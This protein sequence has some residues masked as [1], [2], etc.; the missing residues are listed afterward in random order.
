MARRD[1]RKLCVSPFASSTCNYARIKGVTASPQRLVVHRRH[2]RRNHFPTETREPHQ[3]L[4]LATDQVLAA[5]LELQVRR[6][7]VPADGG[8]F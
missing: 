7:D 5:H 4:A 6:C 1:F 3:R 2:M 8:Y